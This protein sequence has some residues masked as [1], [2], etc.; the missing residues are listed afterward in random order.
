[1]LDFI[2]ILDLQQDP[3]AASTPLST[4]ASTSD[5]STLISPAKRPRTEVDPD[6]EL[7]ETGSSAYNDR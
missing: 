7:E 1:M 6:Y 3:L 4:P 2:L 5:L